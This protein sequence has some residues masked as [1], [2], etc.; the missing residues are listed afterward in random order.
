MKLWAGNPISGYSS[1]PAYVPY[2]MWQ[3]LDGK[4][5]FIRDISLR[6]YDHMLLAG[7]AVPFPVH[8]RHGSADGM[9]SH[10]PLT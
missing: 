4:K 3:P 8:V 5:A 2:T 9:T 1:I 6:S 7:N 10:Y